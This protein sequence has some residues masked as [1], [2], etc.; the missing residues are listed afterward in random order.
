MPKQELQCPFCPK[1]SSRGTGLASHIRGA[2]PKQYSGWSGSRK[3]VQKAE[4]SSGSSP[5][6]V[7]RVGGLNE[8]IARLERQK[9]AIERALTALQ[10]VEGIDSTPTVPS[11]GPEAHTIIPS[12]RNR[13]S[14]GQKKRW[15]AKRA[16][17][18]VPAATPQKAAPRKGRLTPE[19]RKRLAEAM[20]RRWAV[21][22]TAAQARKRGRK[23]A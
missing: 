2:H 10:E 16:A 8:I 23:A 13:W 22:R 3:S 12:G 7:S 21:K 18:D 17:E 5:K 14:E 15:A 20:R 4:G 6:G 19:G 11:N 1:T 9:A